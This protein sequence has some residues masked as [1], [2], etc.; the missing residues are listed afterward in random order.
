MNRHE[1]H[2]RPFV[3]PEWRVE[4]ASSGIVSAQP[5]D[6]SHSVQIVQKVYA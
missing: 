5:L 2:D 6:S 3:F 1:R 4:L